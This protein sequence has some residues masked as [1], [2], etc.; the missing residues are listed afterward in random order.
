MSLEDRYSGQMSREQSHD[1][2][3]AK[4]VWT[5]SD[6]LVPH[7]DKIFTQRKGSASVL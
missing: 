6:H 2:S 5:S 3:M 4:Q 7:S 1:F